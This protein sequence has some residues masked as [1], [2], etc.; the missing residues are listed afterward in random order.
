MSIASIPRWLPNAISCVRVL[1]VPLWVYFAEWAN[2]VGE[3]GDDPANLR[4]LSAGVL[5]TIGAS[6][7]VDGWL[8]RRFSLQSRFGANLDAIADKLAQVVLTTYLALR[9]GPV[10]PWIPYWFLGLL[11]VRDGLLL[12]GFVLIMRRR[13]N[14]EADH[15]W[16]GKASSLCLF[17]VLVV[18]CLGADDATVAIL[19][20]VT[21]ALV[22]ASTVSYARKGVRQWSRES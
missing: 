13:G 11:I 4:L 18:A 8:A 6:D 3:E 16:H 21:S 22:V 7:V 1:L 9:I 12:V 10:F 2:R 20:A 14:V 17:G 5:V 19:S 15:A